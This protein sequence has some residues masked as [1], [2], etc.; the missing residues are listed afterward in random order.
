MTAFHHRLAGAALS[1][2]KVLDC[3]QTARGVRCYLSAGKNWDIPAGADVAEIPRGLRVDLPAGSTLG[4]NGAVVA[5]APRPAAPVVPNGLN[6][7]FAIEVDPS[8]DAVRDWLLWHCKRHGA[9]AAVLVRRLA[10]D[11]PADPIALLEAA[12]GIE[13]LEQFHLVDCDLPLGVAGKGDMRLRA[14]APETPG[15]ALLPAPAP[16]PYR[17]AL[18]ELAL[19][20]IVRDGWLSEARAVLYCGISDFL[21]PGRNVFDAAVASSSFLKFRGKRRYPW[22]VPADRPARVIDHGCRSFDGYPADS[23][24]CVAPGGPLHAASWRPFRISNTLPDTVSQDFS[25]WR[26]AGIRHPGVSAS[27]LVAKTS[28]VPDA[29]MISALSEVFPMAPLLPAEPQR[30][31]APENDRVLVITCMK[32]EGPFILEWLAYHRSIGVED[33]LVYTNDCTDGTDAFFDLLQEKGL[34]EHRRNPFPA[35][36]D[37]PQHAALADAQESDVASR[38]GWII[39]MDVDEYINIHVGDGHLSDLFAAVGEA[40][41]ISLTWR[42]FGN[43]EIPEFRDEF[44]TDQ[45]T[46]CAPLICRKPHQAW[47]FKTLF[48]NLGF[49]KKFGVHRPKGFRSEYLDQVHWVNGSGERMPQYYIRQG[50]RSSLSTYGY[51]LVTLNHYALRSAES[52]LVKRDRGRVNHVDRDQGM[53]YWFRM[54]HNTEED[55]SIHRHAARHRAEY[56]RLL[57]DPEIAAAHSAMVKAHR[58]KI[59][60][61]R[62]RPDYAAFFNDITGAKLNALSYA[63]DRFGSRIFKEGPSEVPDE[64]H[65]S[66]PELRRQRRS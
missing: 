50:W 59:A 12:Q 6:C 29:A 23:I 42:L 20:E 10:P 62:D 66:A 58:D 4:C 21:E 61:L 38:A 11:S 57:A 54:N 18:T 9:H 14:Y 48:R 45:F 55:T 26:M 52:F 15:K 16:D 2:A 46:R 22:S 44:V 27:Q 36:G 60:E 24:W 51:D 1:S 49:Y 35:I 47:G 39:C 37:T 53:N 8:P 33:F 41:M 25:Y 3:V 31:E 17:S 65:R 7:L 30:P 63:M 43:A 32:N 56:G 40:N 5:L 13:G 34:V 64:L 28:L 19:L